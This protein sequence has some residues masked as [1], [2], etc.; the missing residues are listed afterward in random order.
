M[1]TP[2]WSAALLPLVV[3]RSLQR[4]HERRKIG[5]VRQEHGD[6]NSHR[7]AGKG[8][9]IAAFFKKGQHRL[10][11]IAQRRIDV[12]VGCYGHCH[13]TSSSEN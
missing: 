3:V 10:R 13:K 1:I 7:R 5:R 4:R 6:R 12:V 11:R 8:R 9:I 2:P